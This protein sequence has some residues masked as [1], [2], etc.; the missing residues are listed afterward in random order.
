MNQVYN[1]IE[2]HIP[3]LKRYALAI[4]QNAT[5]AD[6]LLQE[7]LT[8]ALTK[9]DLF[10]PGTDLRAWLFT[11]MHNIHA[12]GM[13]A[14]QRRGRQVT[15]ESAPAALSERPR[16]DQ[17]LVVRT[18][19]AALKELPRPQA[20]TLR[21][22]TIDGMAYEDIA[23]RLGVSVGTVKSRVARGRRKLRHKMNGTTRRRRYDRSRHGPDHGHA[24]SFA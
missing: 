20:R 9:A 7:S 21:L 10:E 13:R 24:P 6:D 11:I 15:A 22:A 18:L 4:T 17:S 5:V 3:Q 8:R 12:S 1:D 14:Q 16:Q 23:R 2:Q 19:D